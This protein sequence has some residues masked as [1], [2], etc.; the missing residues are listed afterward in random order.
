MGMAT[1]V[2]VET[3]VMLLTTTQSQLNTPRQPAPHDVKTP[4]G[5]PISQIYQQI[6]QLRENRKA[7]LLRFTKSTVLGR[8]ALTDSGAAARKPV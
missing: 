1:A 2:P 5:H 8:L 7:A 4:P 3:H 6:L